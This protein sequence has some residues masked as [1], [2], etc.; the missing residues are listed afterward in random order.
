MQA[1]AIEPPVIDTK[2]PASVMA[3]TLSK[4]I[5]ALTGVRF[6]AAAWVVMFHFKDEFSKLLPTFK[7]IDPFVLQGSLAVPLFFILSGF[8]LSHTYFSRYRLREHWKFIFLR[9][10]RLWPVHLATILVLLLYVGLIYAHSGAFKSDNFSF[11]VLP[12]ELAMLRGWFSKDLIWN[13][14]AWS[15][16]CE[17]FAYLFVF[18]IAFVCF[19]NLLRPLVLISVIMMLLCLHCF[20]P[21]NLPGRCM[22]ILF[23]FLAGSAL[24]RLRVLFSQRSVH[25]AGY[26]GVIVLAL[27][28]GTASVCSNFLIHLAFVLLI[29]GLSYDNGILTKLFSQKLVVYG[30]AISY[31]IYMTHAVVGKFYG[32]IAGK[33]ALKTEFECVFTFV[34]LVAA[35]IITPIVFYHFVEVPCNRALR[36]KVTWRKA[37]REQALVSV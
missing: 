33:L 24:Y 3:A 28:L 13:Y 14:P 26:L 23:L 20:L 8:I 2:V 7:R 32:A 17:W 6:F 34:L 15:I 27:G 5:Q 31:S 37:K 11:L 4:D 1:R 21:F 16:H 10:A 9:F 25:W 30:G 22:D 18:P 36:A 35:L 12:T 29:L 19:R